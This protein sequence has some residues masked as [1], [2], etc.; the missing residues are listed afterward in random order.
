MRFIKIFLTL[1][2]F[3]LIL[4]VATATFF[5]EKVEN[6]LIRQINNN[7]TTELIIK[8]DI[9]FSF[10][11]DFPYASLTLNKVSIRESLPN[12]KRNL[13][14]TEQ[15]AF[16]LN[17]GDVFAN[18]YRIQKLVIR[19]GQLN[20]RTLQEGQINYD[21]LKE[22]DSINTDPEAAAEED[23][24]LSL[25]QTELYNIEVHYI[26]EP[27]EQEF[28]FTIP[29]G[30]FAGDFGANH[31]VL[32]A[33]GNIESKQ[34]YIGQ[35]DYLPNKK[36][37]LNL[38]MDI[39]WIKELYTFQKSSLDIEGNV[40]E[41]NGTLQ[42]FQGYSNYDLKLKGVDLAFA[43]V[44]NM[45]PNEYKS[46]LEG[47]SSSG[48]ML[49]DATVKGKYSPYQQPQVNVN[50]ELEKGSVSHEKLDYPLKNMR[51]K[52]AFTNGSSQNQ[53][54][55]ELNI[56]NVS[57]EMAGELL[58]AY[59]K[60]TNFEKPQLNVSFD[61]LVYLKAFR[62]MAGE[63]GLDKLDGNVKVDKLK[64]VGGLEEFYNYDTT[65]PTMQGNLK[66]KDVVFKYNSHWVEKMEGEM[67]VNNGDLQL[68]DLQIDLDKSDIQLNGKLERFVPLLFQS[69][70]KDSVVLS[71]PIKA[72]LDLTS[73]FIS[74]DE[75]LEFRSEEETAEVDSTK[76]VDAVYISSDRQDY[77]VGRI[78]PHIE[79]LQ[80]EKLT[81]EDIEGELTF[82]NTEFII[83]QILMKIA[84]GKVDL[85]GDFSVNK[86][87]GLIVKLGMDAQGIDVQQLFEE[88]DNFGQTMMTDKNIKGT[89][90]TKMHL[91]AYFN[92]RLELD[93]PKLLMAADVA[94][95]DGELIDFE[96]MK[97]L[98]AFV[99]VSEL[100]RVR[101]A[102]LENQI[103][104]AHQK[105]RIPTM[106]INSNVTRIT[107]SGLHTFENRIL[108]Y[109][110]VNL[111]DIL[112]GKFK[113]KN[114]E[115]D[116]DK[117]PNGGVNLHLVM[118]GDAFD[119]DIKYMKKKAVKQQFENDSKRSKTDIGRILE[120]EFAV[121][122]GTIPAFAP[123]TFQYDD[124]DVG[125]IDW[126][127]LKEIEQ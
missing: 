54:T 70:M 66:A 57:F 125:I 103:Q 100:E 46:N 124:S 11:S 10:I 51:L 91:K 111:L 55:S 104:I 99:K 40:F 110:R 30:T 62:S 7:L 95:D 1:I 37:A 49:F 122:R 56:E 93:M 72:D 15:M 59:A 14:E 84:E 3:A 113:K 61:G 44:L 89:L 58:Q 74:M 38:Q 94:I 78:R 85:R 76:L 33:K 117:N 119:P 107:F 75:L 20:L 108:Y 81:I 36:A 83:E 41:M 5:E 63:F 60:I 8:G 27:L 31:Y 13:L 26:D 22:E 123:R 17:W 9:G 73:D 114:K 24:M 127:E 80:R 112:L 87:E 82:N 101:F 96:P 43:K 42:F 109:V 6:F 35:T 16:L 50:F 118:Q 69:A 19:D 86:N 25:Q 53:R 64:M 48:E 97:S 2:I 121:G 98:S 23:M 116:P 67:V 52:G 32:N 45:M 29:D 4:I 90:S 77:I 21:I 105:M 12:S 92:K 115:I 47:L 65:Y 102:R 68:K 88:M 106:F 39:D 71:R 18:S 34:F 28:T 120:E 126:S 79:K